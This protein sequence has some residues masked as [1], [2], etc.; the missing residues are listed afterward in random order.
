[1]VEVSHQPSRGAVDCLFFGDVFCDLV[2]TGVDLPQR[3]AEVFSSA[4]A[5]SPGGCANR[6]VAAARAGARSAV[7]AQVGDDALS[8]AVIELLGREPGLDLT[9]LRVVP[10]STTSV[11]VALSTPAERSFITHLGDLTPAAA[12]G[13][14]TRPGSLHVGLGKPVPEWVATL[15]AGGTEVVGGVGWD[16][17]E[18]WSRETLDRLSQVDIAVLNDTEATAYTRTRTAREALAELSHR[19]GLTVVTRGEAGA[20]ALDARTGQFSE[21]SAWPVNAVDPTGAG[22]VFVGTFMAARC[23]GW[24]LPTQLRFACACASLSTTGLG[25]AVSA[26]HIA[27][28]VAYIAANHPAGDWAFL[29]EA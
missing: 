12:P 1:M 11:T 17:T 25:G 7:L 6:A 2:F 23:R 14:L 21:A 22:D 26:P 20:I 4:F 18:Q 13:G 10:G 29:D 15:R 27:D 19:V 3:G 5:V 24:D 16:A 8:R 28:L 9:W